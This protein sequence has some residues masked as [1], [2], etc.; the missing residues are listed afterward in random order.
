[1]SGPVD[2]IGWD[3]SRRI[4]EQLSAEIDDMAKGLSE[5]GRRDACMYVCTYVC[6]YVCT[7]VCRYVCVLRTLCLSIIS[8]EHMA[9]GLQPTTHSPPLWRRIHTPSVACLWMYVCML[10]HQVAMR[11][12]PWQLCALKHLEQSLGRVWPQARMEVYG[13]LVAD[14]TPYATLPP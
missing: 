1:M 14:C 8:L 12:R 11:R 9:H 2:L 13:E 10:V 4:R 3:T 6:M 7:Y 5:V